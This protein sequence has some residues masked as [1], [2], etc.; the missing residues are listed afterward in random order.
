[1]KHIIITSEQKHP[2]DGLSGPHMTV[3]NFPSQKA[4]KGLEKFLFRSRGRSA[5]RV[6]QN[7]PWTLTATKRRSHSPSFCFQPHFCCLISTSLAPAKFLHEAIQFIN[8]GEIK[9]KKKNRII[10]SEQK[11]HQKN[12]RETICFCKWDYLT[13]SERYKNQLGTGGK[14]NQS[15][16]P[17]SHRGEHSCSLNSGFLKTWNEMLNCFTSDGWLRVVL[18]D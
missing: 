7:Y 9:K 14:G 13:E 10:K 5:H 11:P 4:K 2:L 6:S 12:S 8:P 16:I 18:P 17:F 15:R 1:M 3:R